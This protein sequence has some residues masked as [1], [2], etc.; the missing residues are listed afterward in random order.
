MVPLPRETRR[1][2]V[3]ALSDIFAPDRPLQRGD[4]DAAG[5]ALLA[6]RLQSFLINRNTQPPLT[7][8]ITGDWGSGKS[9]VLNLLAAELRVSG[10]RAVWF[11][12]WHHQKE[13]HLFAALLQA[14][15]Q[16]AVPP[17]ATRAGM[18]VRGRLFWARVMRRRWLWLFWLALLAAVGGAVW[19]MPLPDARTIQ[20]AVTALGTSTD[21]KP[22]ET[23]LWKDVIAP[24][25]GPALTLAG[26]IA[27]LATLRDRLKSSGL[28]PGKLM[29]MAA[30][31]TR[32][33][34][35]GGQLAFRVRF[36]EALKEV[37]DALANNN[38]TI[39]VD[40]LD[41]CDPRAVAEVMEA[42]NF[43][44]SSANCFIVLAVA[45]TQVLKA[46]GLAHAEMAK[47]MAPERLTDERAVRDH[48]AQRYLDKLIQIEMPVPRFDGAA[49]REMME[50]ALRPRVPSPDRAWVAAV[51][52]L[53][54]VGVLTV[55]WLGGHH[56][57]RTLQPPPPAPASATAA[58]LPVQAAVPSPPQDRPAEIPAAPPGGQ[59]RAGIESRAPASPWSD[60]RLLAFAL[61]L[62]LVMLA[63]GLHGWRRRAVA[64]EE[65]APE[66]AR[67]LAHWSAAAFAA[68]PSP[69]EMKR[70]L[71]RLRLAATDPA[72][73]ADGTT[74]ALGVFAHADPGMLEDYLLT[75]T[76]FDQL[77]MLGGETRDAAALERWAHISVALDGCRGPTQ[78]DPS[79]TFEPSHD[80]VERFLAAWTGF[81]IRA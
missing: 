57:W 19:A 49:A 69:R 62:L 67:A 1:L 63:A 64:D 38:L 13:E 8:A 4:P 7:L 31:A 10:R 79:L 68:R 6:R 33:R 32:W 23:R 55:A 51:A 61:P 54:V 66:F 45:K 41:R 14:V 76:S 37:T 71:N 9:S 50:T 22:S 28:D 35:L 39:L 24:L 34:D 77:V 56:G 46:M 21:G 25:A 29:A 81:T 48:Y 18:A 20:D 72:V 42:V 16:Q 47:E 65:D 2:S 80:R 59:W 26:L 43:L 70:F 58:A 44:T 52:A 30:G 73:P 5:A 60:W 74:V 12:A 27:A 40:D 75:G 53:G 36:A 17:L 3:G 15:R 11:N 78:P